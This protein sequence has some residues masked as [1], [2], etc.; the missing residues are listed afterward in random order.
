MEQINNWTVLSKYKKNNR[1][2][3]TCRCKCGKVFERRY[4]CLKNS[5]GCYSCARTKHGLHGSKLYYVWA[6]IKAR[7]LN[8]NHPEYHNYGARGIYVCED[9]KNSYECFYNWAQANGYK[10]GLTIDR[11]NNDSGYT[12][13]NCRWTDCH[14]QNLNKR[15]KPSN[16]GIRGVYHMTG[17]RR[18]PY[19]AQFCGV[20]LGTFETIAEAVAARNAAIIKA[21]TV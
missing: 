7:C 3:C 9:W 11:I 5:N 21:Q 13:E 1:V 20:R 4:D 18:R 16:T 8:Q 14:A 2:F 10:E 12:P 6:Q 17:N 15:Y 19:E